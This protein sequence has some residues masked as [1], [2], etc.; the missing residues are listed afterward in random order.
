[1]FFVRTASDR[2]LPLVRDVLL[3]TLPDTYNGIY[4]T[5]K[6]S[7][8]I[9]QWCSLEKLEE[10]RHAPA[11]EFLVADNGDIVGGM[12]YASQTD[13]TITLHQIYVHPK[14]QNGKSGLHLMIE[15]ENSFLDAETIRL[16][17]E[18]RNEKAINFFNTYGFKSVSKVDSNEH[19]EH[20][21]SILVMEKPVVYA[22]D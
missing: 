8:I 15:I 16:E 1:L 19:F 2:D 22:E 7:E 11:S 6:V 21:V 18:E 14:Y 5:E 9:S 12:A 3:N 20:Q 13:K 4:G 17:V 10:Q